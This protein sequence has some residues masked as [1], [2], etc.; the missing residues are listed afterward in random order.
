[1]DHRLGG[2]KKNYIQL[3]NVLMIHQIFGR[4][5]FDLHCVAAAF[6]DNVEEVILGFT[7]ADRTE[8]AIREQNEP[9][10]TL[11]VL[12]QDLERIERDKV[13]FPVLSHA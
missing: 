3:G 10:G 11:F 6:G 9:G 2:V 1:M 12:G 8:L 4:Q 5:E 13:I 7:P